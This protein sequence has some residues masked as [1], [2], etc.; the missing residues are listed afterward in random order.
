MVSKN[1]SKESK[2]KKPYFISEVSSN[3]FQDLDRVIAFVDASADAGFDAVK[4]QLFKIDELFISDVLEKSEDHRKRK[5]WELPIE[6]LPTIK[7]RCIERNIDLGVTPFY[8]E[9][10]NESIK[11][12]DFLKIASYELLW[13]KLIDSCL[14]TNLPLF[15]STGM[16]DINEIESVVNLVKSKSA[17]KVQLLHCVS[18]YPAPAEE[19]NLSAID[20][21]R[22]KFS[23]P[24]GWSD[25]TLNPDVVNSACIRWN[26]SCVE[27]H[28]DLDGVG[29]EY[30]GGHCWLP[31]QAKRLISSVRETLKFDGTGNKVPANCE[32]RERLWR[33][34][35][36]DGLR[37]LKEIRG[38]NLF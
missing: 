24:V 13:T 8:L 38:E 2:A 36:S 35:P 23:I 20:T 26:A 11:Y 4:F 25:H 7:K 22:N 9:A 17:D 31:D 29:E 21:I 18:N 28:L 34:D 12:V 37:P 5:K 16:A 10:V 30:S 6:F 15:I 3:H 14:D 33:A 27:M 1:S 19:V 32:A